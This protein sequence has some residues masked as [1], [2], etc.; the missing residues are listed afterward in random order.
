MLKLGLRHTVATGPNY[1]FKIMAVSE[2]LLKRNQ[3]I[4][5]LDL[6]KDGRHVED[7]VKNTLRSFAF[8]FIRYTDRKK[9]KIL[10]EL[11]VNYSILKPDPSDYII[12]VEGLFS[13]TSKFIQTSVGPTYSYQ[14]FHF[15]KL[16]FQTFKLW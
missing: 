16:S 11:T 12:S 2:D 7:K 9:V 13:D 15:T 10:D 3:R 4:S 6:F 1:Q 5:N 8:N 14:T